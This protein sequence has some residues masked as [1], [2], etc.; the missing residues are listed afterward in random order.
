[1]SAQPHIVI[2]G[3]GILGLSTALAISE[4]L[5]ISHDITIIAEYGPHN[6][7][8]NVSMTNFPKY[9]SPWAG[10]HFRPFPSKNPQEYSE[11]K[12]TRL[13]LKK[14][15]QL[16]VEHPESSIKFVE[17]I[18][19]LEAPDEFYKKI[20]DG[21]SNDIENFTSFNDKQTGVL[22]FKYD[23]WVVNAPLYLQFLY[24]K[25]VTEHH[26]RFLNAKLS[27]LRQVND[28]ISNNPIIIN[29]TGV[30]LQYEGG[31]DPKSY[32]IR[33]QTLL[34]N[35]PKGCPYLKKTITYQH[36]DGNWTFVIPRPLDGGIILGGTKQV[37]D[38][39]IGIKQEDT[40]ALLKRG[41]KYFPEL[42]REKNN[43][44]FFDILKVNVGLRPARVSGLNI[45]TE[46][47]ESN[48]VI[49]NYGAGGMGYELSYGS[50]LMVFENLLEL[51]S[52]TY[53]L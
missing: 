18:E 5:K 13:T 47:Y 12:L 45:S 27:S 48:H 43:K 25:L 4:H 1:M 3:A 16:A 37:G 44:K 28:Y 10:A 17:G 11:M 42:M 34:I 2:V 24:R 23:T 21:Y 50:G 53:K 8:L 31:V 38:S 41:E 36:A 32:P 26:V 33:G 29:C 14:F 51:L 39:F 15:K 6:Q 49:N 40:D 46:H 7:S 35:P 30:G 20:G 22:G 19:Y 52:R 9:T